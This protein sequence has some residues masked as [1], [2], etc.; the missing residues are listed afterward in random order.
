MQYAVIGI[1]GHYDGHYDGSDTRTE[2]TWRLTT[3]SS[4]SSPGLQVSRSEAR[5][6]ATE[7]SVSRSTDAP[8]AEACLRS[9][10]SSRFSFFQLSSLL[11]RFL[12][13]LIIVPCRSVR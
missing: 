10:H 9:A 12:S 13:M 3:E 6:E 4:V 2:A 8:D 7:W 1:Y 11:L 5:T